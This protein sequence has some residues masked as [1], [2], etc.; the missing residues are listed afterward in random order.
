MSAVA[1]LLHLYPQ[2]WFHED[3]VIVGNRDG[4]LALQEAIDQALATG[5]ASV[6]VEPSDGEGNDLL[7]L[8]LD[9]DW[10]SPGWQNLRLPYTD[11]IASDKRPDTVDP[12]DLYHRTEATK[13]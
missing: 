1:K 7:V 10:Q 13:E 8:L 11:E 3:A 2:P 5:K 12:V 9:A 4:L 6:T